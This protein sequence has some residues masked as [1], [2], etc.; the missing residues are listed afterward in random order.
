MVWQ[1]YELIH[2]KR[3]NNNRSSTPSIF[4]H[5]LWLSSGSYSTLF[6]GGF[7]S[8]AAVM[9]ARAIPNSLLS[10]LPKPLVAGAT[11]VPAI[12]LGVG[13]VGNKN[14]FWHLLRN[15]GTYRKEFKMIKEEL[16]NS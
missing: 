15:Y 4:F 5:R 10:G 7:A 16:Y 3:V 12:I 14:E 2:T 1:D 8:Y 6:L 11:F 9:H 13:V